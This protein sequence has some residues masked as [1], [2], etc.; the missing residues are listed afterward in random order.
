MPG[1]YVLS[2]EPRAGKTVVVLGIAEALASRVPRIAVFRP[3]VREDLEQDRVLGLVAERY[4]VPQPH[5]QLC[6]ATY[7]RARDLLTAGRRD[8]LYR[9]ILERYRAL[10]ETADVVLCVGTDFRGVSAT[11]ELDFNVEVAQHLGTPLIPVLKGLHRTPE[12]VT[13]M[14]RVT[15]EALRAKNSEPVAL[16]VNR[17]APPDRERLEADLTQA[18][19]GAFAV[20]VLPEH[21]LLEAPTV[22]EVAQAL[23]AELVSGD[24]AWLDADVRQTKVGAME[25][26]HFLDHL[27]DGSLIITPG[28][29]SDIILGTLAA[30]LA[31]GYPR[32]AA[33]VLTGGLELAPQVKRLLDGLGEATVPVLGVSTDT[34][35]TAVRVTSVE[36]AIAPGDTRKITA[37]LGL[38]ESALDADALLARIS[39]APSNR[40]T[41]LMFQYELIERARRERRR[42]VLPEGTEERILR[43]AEM[44][45]LR[46]VCEVTLLGNADD[47]GRKIAALGLALHDVDVVDPMTSDRRAA[48]ADTYRELRRHKGVSKELAHDTMA[49]LSYFGTMMVHLGH[50][51]G[52]VSGS[53]HTTA[54][55]IRPA[56]EFVRTRPGISLVSSVFFMCLADR[57]LVYGDCAVNPDPTAEQLAEIAV[58]A[59]ATADAFG[60]EPRVA[61]LSYATGESGKGPEVDKVRA[62]TA[63]ARRLRPDLKVEGP[64]Q[65]DAAVDAEVAKV[66]MP[67]S[68]VAGQATVFIF[69]D[70][71]AGNSAYKAVQRTANALA[72][73]PVLQGLNKPVN[74]LSR[75]ATVLDIVNTIA[76]T[77][78]QAQSGV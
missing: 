57:V 66:K 68:E 48:Y 10:A 36:P 43:A 70:L 65:Y 54:H 39:L 5:D 38:M 59:A 9:E 75:G 4:A 64:I 24:P 33:L 50:A 17:A 56:L 52:M 2:A 42:I 55:T 18:L 3:L 25:L 7:A 28:D 51:D 41:P 40:R 35:A 12:Q 34:F 63:I 8:D 44:V 67:R 30:S 31:R 78:I 6:G 45:R 20:A 61:M 73:G 49:D 74:D 76:I 16:V 37:T 27:E 14:A 32:I 23:G 21:P 47:V 22:R 19:A 26:P 15:V 11:L 69:P 58:S 60:I 1:V 71:N 13:D 77:A 46:D 62:A 53:V 29:R 72:I